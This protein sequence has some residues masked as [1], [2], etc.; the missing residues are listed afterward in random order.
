[1]ADD[2][3]PEI[4]RVLEPLVGGAEDLAYLIRQDAR[5]IGM[6]AAYARQHGVAGLIRWLETGGDAL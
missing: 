1:M 5:L 4:L 3:P 6:L 2:S